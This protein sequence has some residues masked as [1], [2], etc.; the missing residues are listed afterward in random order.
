[1]TETKI[2]PM[3]LVDYIDPGSGVPVKACSPDN[4]QTYK[5]YFT[6]WGIV[7]HADDVEVLWNDFLLDKVKSIMS[8]DWDSIK[9]K[10]KLV[11]QDQLNERLAKLSVPTINWSDI[12]NKPDLS[13]YVTRDE[14]PA[15][16]DLSGYAKIDDI[17]QSMTW[18][19]IT[20]KPN[21]AT[22][23]DVDYLKTLIGSSSGSGDAGLTIEAIVELIKH[24]L[25]AKVDVNSGNLL[26]DVDGVSNVSI[27]DAVATKVA[28]SLQ[29]KL[30]GSDLVAEIGGTE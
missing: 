18:S 27:A 12:Q 2:R 16:P 7:W 19:Q 29:L 21:V 20:G 30:Q 4:G 17:P 15:Q 24:H 26:I 8:I 9:N 3:T 28:Q 25:K 6:P 11:T 14:L 5:I 23:D 22:K 13:Q 1:M 10:P